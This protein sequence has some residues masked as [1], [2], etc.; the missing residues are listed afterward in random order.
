MVMNLLAIVALATTVAS[1][2]VGT[3]FDALEKRDRIYANALLGAKRDDARVWVYG[4]W[5]PMSPDD[6][7][8]SKKRAVQ[9]DNGLLQG[10]ISDNH[11]PFWPYGDMRVASRDVDNPYPYGSRTPFN[12]P[13]SLAKRFGL[14]EGEEFEN[15][16]PL[17]SSS[18]SQAAQHNVDNPYPYGSRTPFNTPRSLAKRFGLLQGEEFES[19]EP[20]DGSSDTQVARRDVDAVTEPWPEDPPSPPP[21]PPR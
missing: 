15:L 17:D 9:L 4:S 2:P 19:L 13:R 6:E 20:L 21:S 16:E 12:T 7:V 18:D 3:S 8:E 1:L 5:P 10:K 14:L 11:P